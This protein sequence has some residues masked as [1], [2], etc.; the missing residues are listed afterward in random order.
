MHEKRPAVSW[1]KCFK[2]LAEIPTD[3]PH[4]RL[5]VPLPLL[6]ADL[7]VQLSFPKS[8]LLVCSI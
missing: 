3:T 1:Q 7:T 2:S 5:S 6:P 8:E 4:L